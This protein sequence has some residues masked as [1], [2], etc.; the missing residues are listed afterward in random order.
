MKGICSN[1]QMNP[2]KVCKT[3]ERGDQGL[4]LCSDL[5]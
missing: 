5:S 1:E 4:R 2:Q 3:G